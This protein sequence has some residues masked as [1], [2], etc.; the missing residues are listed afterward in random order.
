MTSKSTDVNI[1]FVSQATSRAS[2]SDHPARTLTER[3]LCEWLI[4]N[5]IAHQHASDVFIVKA[6]ANGSPQ[7]FVPDI[8]LKQKTR[9]GQTIVLESLHSFSPKR[10]GMKALHAF[11]RQYHEQFCV[12]LIG[13]KAL[14]QSVP[15]N[16]ADL[17]CEL[18]SL[19]TLAK[20]LEKVM[21]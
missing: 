21:A 10:G 4:A 19:D 13:K 17:R 11:C 2:S 20:K 7:L 6:A 15:K 16:I 18:E 8:T 14:L 9:D 5:D 12:V 1:R 3:Q